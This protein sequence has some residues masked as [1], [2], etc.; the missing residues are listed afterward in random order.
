MKRNTSIFGIILLLLTFSVEL[1]KLERDNHL[2]HVVYEILKGNHFEKIVFDDSRSEYIFDRYVK[3]IDYSKRFLLASDY[4]KFQ[5]H[6]TKLDDEIRNSE[7]DFFEMSYKILMKRQKE[8]KDY[9][10]KILAHKMNFNSKEELIIDPDLMKYP[11][12]RTERFKYWE[13]IITY[14]VL[15]EI[16]IILSKQEEAIKKNDTTVQIK[17]FEEIEKE[18][19]AIVKKNYND[20]FDRLSKLRRGDYFAQYIEAIVQ[21]CDYHTNYFPPKQK[22]N[23]KM[24]L[25]GELE[26]IGAVLSQQ[27]GEIK[28][29]EI[30]IGGAAWKQ[31]D[32]KEGDIIQKVAQKGK[33]PVNITDMRL[34]DAVSLIRG[35]KGS[36]VT[37]TVKKVDGTIEDI[38]IVRDKLIIEES[39]IRTIILH[40]SLTN[41][42]VGYLYLPSFYADFS[43]SRNGRNCAEDFKKEL[44]K[45]R[46]ENIDGL[47]IDLRNN[48]GGSL[49]EVVKIT[50]YFIEKGPIVQVRDRMGRIYQYQD[51]DASIIYDD[52]VLVMTNQFSASASEILSAALQ[53]YNRA[54]IY[55]TKQTMGKGSVQ[56]VVD[57]DNF[58]RRN[59]RPLGLLK[60][61]IQ[62]FYRIN[63]GS[64]QI[65][66]VKADIVH[67]TIFAE[68][69][70]YERNQDNAL[71]WDE[72]P[73]MKYDLWHPKYSLDSLRKWS[74]ARM[75]S[76]SAFIE[77][78]TYAKQMKSENDNMKS[79]PL[80]LEAYKKLLKEKQENRKHYNTTIGKKVPIKFSY[81]TEDLKVMEADTLLKYRYDNW[82]KR[83]KT[84]F[85]LNEAYNIVRDMKKCE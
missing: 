35:K 70:Y 45:L 55:G 3:N 63:G 68:L 25:S 13:K 1:A 44:V 65:E 4:R 39:Y 61:T 83:I 23:L 76:D 8:V 17:S 82:T 54:V 46:N 6:K 42:R 64:T 85:E 12:N 26:G 67:P 14:D 20:Y 51:K 18:A 60:L 43:E 38:T 57:L 48:G 77:T 58:A 22:T 69:D 78:T 24:Q 66:G 34:D 16:N 10:D 9:P 36:K 37:L 84:D 5:K 11:R 33:E 49:G 59:L 79:V 41:N 74:Y 52:N 32:L 53:D 27:F 75:N 31:G 73:K 7:L 21:S 56:R 2:V 72:I 71:K 40:D 50:G 30:M 80:N 47:I 29:R 81:L 28:V 62:K 15:K 19:R